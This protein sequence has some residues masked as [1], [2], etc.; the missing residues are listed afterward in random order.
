MRANYINHIFAGIEVWSTVA[1][2]LLEIFGKRK[3]NQGYG[4]QVYF[5]EKSK[6]KV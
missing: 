5:L 6:P 4:T 3:V 2:C 1:G